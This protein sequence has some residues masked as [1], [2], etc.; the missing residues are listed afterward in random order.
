MNKSLDMLTER[1]L[2]ILRLVA[3]GY[4]NGE[5]ADQLVLSLGT[6][7]WYNGQIFDKLDVRNRT[8][9][10]VRGRELGLLGDDTD[11]IPRQ[12]AT[13]THLPNY[14]L[15][16]VGRQ[17]ELTRIT[18]LL[19]E[20]RL[21][22]LV[23]PGGIGKTRMAVE[24]ARAQM[25]YFGDG[26]YFVALAPLSSPEPIV[27]IIGA[28]MNLNFSEIINVEPR[29]QLL[30]H[31]RDKHALLVLD[32][33]DELL[34]GVGLV[35]EIL[36][37]AS[38]VK[39]LV[40]SRERL[41][42]QEETLF[43]VEGMALPDATQTVTENGAVQLFVQCSQR[44]RPDMPFSEED[45]RSVARICE[46]VEGMPLGI[47]LAAAWVEMLSPREIADEIA[48][49]FDFLET[50]MRNMPS[51]HRSVRV[52]FE[53]AWQ[54]LTEAERAVFAKL[55]IF[56]GGFTRG[57]AAA[58]AGAS[59]PTLMALVNKS[60]LRREP[61]GCFEIHELLRQYAAEQ[62]AQLD[63]ADDSRRA[64]SQY[65]LNWLQTL[66]E[67]DDAPGFENIRVAWHWA[68]DHDQYDAIENALDSLYEF[69]TRRSQHWDVLHMF[70]HAITC[71]HSLNTM[72]EKHAQTLL[73]LRECRGK[74]R[75]LTG[76]FLGAVADL[77]HVRYAAHAAGDATWER[78]LLIRLGQLYRKIEQHNEAI[79]Y[80]NKVVHF[81]R[82]NGNLRGVADALYHMGTVAWD[83]GDNA[84]ARLY[85][86][87]AVDIAHKL[88][89]RDVVAVQA[90]H[91]LGES[92]MMA[93]QPQEAIANFTLSQE[94]AEEIGDVSYV[95][96][97]L[98]MIGWANIGTIGRGDYQRAEAAFT[99]SLP[100]S[101]AAHME[102][103]NVCS[104][105]GLG[106]TQGLTGRY[107]E[108]IAT[109]REGLRRAEILG[110]VRFMC[111]ALDNL[112]HLY[113][114]LNLL[115]R[116][117]AAHQQVMDLMLQNESTY[118]LPRAQANH[119]I[120]RIR[121]GDLNVENNLIAALDLAVSR[122]QEFHAV[123]ALEGLAELGIARQDA[124]FA[125]RYADQLLKLAEARGMQEMIAQARRWRGEA[126]MLT[127]QLDEAQAELMQAAAAA[128]R[129]GRVRLLRDIHATLA[130]RAEMAG[131]ADMAQHHRQLAQKAVQRM[132][133]SVDSEDLRLGLV[134]LI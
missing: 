116:A 74:I 31:L 56:R 99:D 86:Q 9:A 121:R 126:L 11:K 77:Q 21:L 127:G 41:N 123:R 69:G 20:C 106:L 89:L 4:S 63:S 35:A 27:T 23:G 42:I 36:H 107:G 30:K 54:M 24:A 18:D 95:S 131:S 10:I 125:C 48:R 132:A 33:F 118:W 72:D 6:V 46:L 94:M 22:T 68:V 45:L 133:D 108:G 101:L 82:Q 104:Y 53:S 66:N 3:E 105:T 110:V 1:E 114:E 111:L 122:E 17:D 43:R 75:Q 124:R 65:Y 14:P 5:I 98:Q 58:V 78:D 34:D 97:N 88:G 80:L 52:V 134:G 13:L 19:R 120:N 2:E 64:H 37:S 87:E 7:K 25:S 39:V 44:V 71:W 61:G 128:T 129:M 40:T 91:G 100:M 59:L 113:Q 109:I 112:G 28:A 50:D 29:T 76:D 60:L 93:G 103:H 92:L 26:V 49:S 117:D 84:Q 70:D 47:V 57:G 51:R 85:H 32:N 130:R 96:E 62:L 81:S 38:G 16:F 8:Q 67:E 79:H 15:P 73:R 90:H 102:W 115:D 12:P 83:E 119:A 55:S